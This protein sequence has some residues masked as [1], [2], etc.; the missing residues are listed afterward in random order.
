[1]KARYEPQRLAIWCF[2]V[3]KNLSPLPLKGQKGASL[4]KFKRAC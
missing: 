2:I 1:M 3:A 4:L